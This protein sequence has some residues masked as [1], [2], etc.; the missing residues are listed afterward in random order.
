MRLMSLPQAGTETTDG[1]RKAPNGTAEEMRWF[2]EAGQYRVTGRPGA[3]GGGGHRCQWDPLA[4]GHADHRTTA[5]LGE[6]AGWGAHWST[7][8][9]SKAAG[10]VRAAPSSAT[11]RSWRPT[12]STRCSRGSARRRSSS[13]IPGRGGT[14]GSTR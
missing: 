2:L 14:T 1:G 4:S 3:R 11:G 12:T 10:T 5:R 13:P 7:A 6:A 9:R 8:S